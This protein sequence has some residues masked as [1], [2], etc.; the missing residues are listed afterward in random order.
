MRCVYFDA[1]SGISG[2]MTVGALLQLGAPVEYLRDQLERVAGSSCRIEVEQVAVGGIWACR[3][4][5]IASEQAVLGEGHHGHRR[6]AE[7]RDQISASGLDPGVRE[8]ALRIF[9]RLAE[10][11]ARVHGVAADDVIFHEVGALDSIA[12]VV[13]AAAGLH[14]LAVEAIYASAFPSGSGTVHSRHGPLPVPAPAVVEL[15]RGF[16]LRLGDGAGELVTP[17]G[18]AIVAALGT[19]GP[20]PVLRLSGVGYGAGAARLADRPNVLRVLLGESATGIERDCVVVVETNIDDAN[21]EWYEYAIERLFAA[22]ALDV[23][24]TPSQMK[25]NRPGVVL[26]VLCQPSDRD[27]V[28]SVLFRETPA[29]GVRF[30]EVGRLKL[31]RTV[32]CVA[33]EYGEV[34]VKVAS[35]GSGIENAAPEFEDCARLARE[36]GVPLKAIYQAALAAFWSRRLKRS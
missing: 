1:F 27:A 30:A 28:A 3:F 31:P 2:D 8:R 21:P 5:A 9:E 4:A 12:D 13:C 26:Q 23:W 14:S 36:S 18:A 10:A 34:R 25:K 35:G 32:E 17:T 6:Y 29:I 22:G 19:P 7:I 20:A 16:E 24:M 33:T 11:E 15:L